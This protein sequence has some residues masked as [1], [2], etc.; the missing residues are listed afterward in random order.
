LEAL[1]LRPVFYQLVALAVE[2]GGDSLGVWSHGH[3]F[4]L[5]DL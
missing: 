5:G 4:G 1:I 2:G 3:F